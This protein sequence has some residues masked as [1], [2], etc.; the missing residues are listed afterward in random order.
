MDSSLIGYMVVSGLEEGSLVV[1]PE[2]CT[3]GMGWGARGGVGWGAGLR[4][5]GGEESM[6]RWGGGRGGL[7]LEDTYFDHDVINFC[8]HP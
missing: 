6:V 8:P 1:S 5:G 7:S 2:S 3:L 4:G